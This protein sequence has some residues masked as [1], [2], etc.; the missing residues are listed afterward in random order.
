MH[1]LLPSSQYLVPFFY[2][3]VLGNMQPSF[4]TTKEPKKNTRVSRTICIL[5]TVNEHLIMYQRW[6]VES[7]I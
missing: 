6:T 5:A 1:Y 4:K 2:G 3:E 7:Q